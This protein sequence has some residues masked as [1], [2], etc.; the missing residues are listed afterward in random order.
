MGKFRKKAS[1]SQSIPTASLPDIIFILLFFFMVATKMRKAD[2][3]VIVN[4][5][6]ASQIQAIPE[7]MESID[8]FIGKPKDVKKYGSAPLIQAGENFIPLDG[9][10][11]YIADARMK[12]P[13]SKRRPAKIIINIK[14]DENLPIGI[15]ID[16]KQKLRKMGIRNLNYTALKQ[17]EI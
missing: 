9:L 12:L 16:V 6:S 7:T 8:L 4:Q 2:P 14:M 3:K 1:V 13:A 10:Y 17:T 11:T 5:A 15:L